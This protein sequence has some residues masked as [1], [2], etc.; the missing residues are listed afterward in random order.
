MHEGLALRASFRY[1]AWPYPFARFVEVKEVIRTSIDP[2]VYSRLEQS[3]FFSG[4]GELLGVSLYV[5]YPNSNCD[6]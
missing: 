6:Q 3:L 4:N 5:N 2:S 1:I